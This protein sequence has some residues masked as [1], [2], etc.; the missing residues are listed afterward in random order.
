MS[1]RISPRPLLSGLVT[2]FSLLALPARACLL[3]GNAAPCHCV[4]NMLLSVARGE[5]VDATTLT[6]VAPNAA[7]AS[8]QASDDLYV[9]DHSGNNYYSQ[10]PSDPTGNGNITIHV[11][12][13]L[14]W[15]MDQ[16][17]HAAHTVTTVPDAPEQFDS[18][19]LFSPGDSFSHTFTIPGEYR[20]YC[21]NHAGYNLVGNQYVT[22]GTQVGT[23]EV[24]PLPEPSAAMMAIGGSMLLVNRRRR[25]GGKS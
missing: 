5:D 25:R 19:F 20:Y 23:I 24:L 3:Q 12:D 15:T 14:T 2:L 11:G 1:S 18:G 9:G 4:E 17:T 10:S 21:E 16:G 6:G 13:T 8:P 7:A 22:Y